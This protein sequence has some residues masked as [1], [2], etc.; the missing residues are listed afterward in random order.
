MA[1]T[2]REND[3]NWTSMAFDLHPWRTCFWCACIQAAFMAACEF[4]AEI[5]SL[6]EPS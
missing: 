5:G 6:C 3:G 1:L 2:A 4:Q